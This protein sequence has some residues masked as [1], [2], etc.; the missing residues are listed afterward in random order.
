M[1]FSG[2]DSMRLIVRLVFAVLML[3]TAVGWSQVAVQA[4]AQST[5]QAPAQPTAQSSAQPPAQAPAQPP[6]QAPAQPSPQAPALIPA[7]NPL[8][9]FQHFSA[10]V[11]GSPLKWNKMQVYRSG[12]QMRADYTLEDEYRISNQASRNGWVIRPIEFA[13]QPKECRRMS[14]TDIATYPFFAFGDKEFD[15][16]RSP[17]VENETLNGHSCKV[18]NYVFKTKDGGQQVKAKLWEAEDLK[19][20]PIQMEIAGS[21]PKFT[22]NYTD[23]SLEPPDPKLFRLPA[24]CHAGVQQKKKPP[25]STAKPPTQAAPK[26]PQ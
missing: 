18:E 20:F 25:A 7:K 16:E 15:V 26:P 23:V 8:D 13:T 22:M 14:L 10:K 9:A 2:D 6:A 12:K 19:G 21:T 24:N 17:A 11:S 4:P 3:A 1:F 5:A